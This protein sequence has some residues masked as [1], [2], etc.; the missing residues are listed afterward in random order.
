MM[1]TRSSPRR[2]HRGGINDE[3]YLSACS[4]TPKLAPHGMCLLQV[5]QEV[6]LQ[7]LMELSVRF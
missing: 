2:L 4:D 3:E 6:Q 5:V 7:N 1:A